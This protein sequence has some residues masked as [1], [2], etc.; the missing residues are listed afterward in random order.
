M[1]KTRKGKLRLPSKRMSRFSDSK[2][3]QKQISYEIIR[4]ANLLEK[5]TNMFFNI[6]T[7]L[8]LYYFLPEQKIIKT[9][10]VELSSEYRFHNNE[11]EDERPDPIIFFQTPPNMCFITA[12]PE[13]INKNN[14]ILPRDKKIILD[15]L[16]NR[17]KIDFQKQAYNIIRVQTIA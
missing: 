16:A 9:F 5:Q 4:L 15:Y 7:A 14:R 13:Q 12:N 1:V 6:S 17:H 11:D 10:L 8:A 3:G 2:L